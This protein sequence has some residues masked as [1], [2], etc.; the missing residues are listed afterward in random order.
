LIVLRKSEYLLH[1]HSIEGAVATSF[2]KGSM[3]SFLAQW[4]GDVSDHGFD[5]LENHMKYGKLTAATL[6]HFNPINIREAAWF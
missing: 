3:D 2:I 4:I 1:F 5:S 6:F